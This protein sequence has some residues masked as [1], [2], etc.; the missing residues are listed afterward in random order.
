METTAYKYLRHELRVSKDNQ[1]LRTCSKIGQR[2]PTLLVNQFSFLEENTIWPIRSTSDDI[3]SKTWTL[4]QESVKNR[5]A[6]Y[7]FLK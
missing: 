6:S 1:N 5:M 7:L 3:G 4:T 2:C